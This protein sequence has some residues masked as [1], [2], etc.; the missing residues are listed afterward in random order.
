MPEHPIHVKLLESLDSTKQLKILGSYLP[1]KFS[2]EMIIDA[3]CDSDGIYSQ[4]G[5]M[6][7]KMPGNLDIDCEHVSDRILTLVSNVALDLSQ[8]EGDV[9]HVYSRATLYFENLEIEF[10]HLSADVEVYSTETVSVFSRNRI[11][12]YAREDNLNIIPGNLT[13]KNN[14][15]IVKRS[16]TL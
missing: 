10:A 16:I 7:T 6:V 3:C 8:V 14:N 13:E 11:T 15:A 9:T 4:D 2:L 12:I 1:E 5:N